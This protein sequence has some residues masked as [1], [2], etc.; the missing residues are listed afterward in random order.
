ML[1]NALAYA[2]QHRGDHLAELTDFLRIPSISTLPEAEPDLRAG[3]AWLAAAM[4]RA[5]LLRVEI[6]PTAGLPV[7]YGEWL[8]AGPEAPT[9]LAYGHYDV[10]PVD[11]LEEWLAPPFEPSVRGDDLFGRGA[12]DDKGQGQDR[13]HPIHYDLTKWIGG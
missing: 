11:P 13:S 10:Q 12:S 4:R 2:C 5:G 3:A 1:D 8:G 6:M 7:V 9:L